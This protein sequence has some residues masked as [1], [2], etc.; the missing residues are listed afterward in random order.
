[1]SVSADL[2]TDLKQYLVTFGLSSVLLLDNGSLILTTRGE[3]ARV[4]DINAVRTILRGAAD[5]ALEEDKKAVAV[6]LLLTSTH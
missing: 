4:A 2:I 3:V 1:M 5:G 6:P